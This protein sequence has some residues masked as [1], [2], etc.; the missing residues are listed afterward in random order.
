MPILVQPET[1]MALPLAACSFALFR[2][3]RLDLSRRPT[4]NNE[5]RKHPECR[6]VR[7]GV[8]VTEKGACV[9]LELGSTK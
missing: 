3:T 6:T 7:H 9:I 4:L 8:A 2:H 5:A 1:P